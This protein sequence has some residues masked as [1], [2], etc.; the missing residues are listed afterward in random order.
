METPPTTEAEEGVYDLRL[1]L[2]ELITVWASPRPLPLR[3]AVAAS[4]FSSRNALRD[5]KTLDFRPLMSFLS[6]VFDLDDRY[7]FC[8][9]REDDGVL[10]RSLP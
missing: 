10:D 2:E 3:F 8:L 9:V 7:D 6:E 4:F 5:P 1:L